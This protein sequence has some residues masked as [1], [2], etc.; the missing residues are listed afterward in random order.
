MKTILNQNKISEIQLVDEENDI[1]EITMSNGNK[2]VYNFKESDC[3]NFN[4][5]YGSILKN[6]LTVIQIETIP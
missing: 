5:F 6:K 1:V 2:Y 3:D 4:Q